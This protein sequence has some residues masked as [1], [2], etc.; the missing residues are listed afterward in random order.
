MLCFCIDIYIFRK[1]ATLEEENQRLTKMLQMKECE[2]TK[3]EVDD[4]RN[5]IFI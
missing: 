4:L 5:S 2:L 1:L 3:T